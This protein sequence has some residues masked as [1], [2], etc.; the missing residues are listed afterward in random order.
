EGGRMITLPSLPRGRPKGT[1]RIAYDAAVLGFC[2]GILKIRSTVDFQVSSRGWCYILE[3]H[4][5]RK[6]DF[7]AAQDLIVECRRQRL[8]PMDIVAEDGARSFD[9]LEGDLDGEPEVFAESGVDWLFDYPKS[10]PPV[11]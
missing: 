11:P 8:L 2:D 9:H 3:E 7:D 1:A 10:C 4:G 5:L 6:G